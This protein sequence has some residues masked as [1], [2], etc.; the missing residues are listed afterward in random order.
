[1]KMTPLRLTL[2]GDFEAR[3]GSGPPLSLRTRKSQA[4]LAYL[5]HPAGHAHSRDKLAVLLWGDQRPAQARARLRETLFALRRALAPAEPGLL[6]TDGNM[7][8]LTATAVRVDVA[9]FERLVRERTPTALEQAATEY[10]GEFL[11]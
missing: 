11:R 9:E 6:Q 3:L 10:R 2:L 5:S 4:L 8:I 1:M 7:V